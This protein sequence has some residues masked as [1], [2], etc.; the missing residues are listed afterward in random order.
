MRHLFSVL[1]PSTTDINQSADNTQ[2]VKRVMKLFSL[3]FGGCSAQPITG[4]WYSKEL[5]EIVIESVTRV[6]AYS[7]H[8]TDKDRRF[9]RVIANIIKRDM[10]QE[11]VAY[12]IIEYAPES[13]LHFA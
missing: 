10:S 6:Y 12:E 4:A 8:C 3:R 13:G 9:L 5:G 2:I 11:S 1:V 7:D